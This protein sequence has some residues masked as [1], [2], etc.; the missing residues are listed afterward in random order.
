[1]ISIKRIRYVVI[2]GD[3]EKIFCGLARNYHLKSIN[4]IGDTPVKTYMSRQKAISSFINS[5][6]C[7]IKDF[8]TGKYK[9]VPVY[10]SIEEVPEEDMN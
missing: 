7:S 10:E 9:V 4:D 6:Y 8:E 5:F 2:T 1:M 3:E